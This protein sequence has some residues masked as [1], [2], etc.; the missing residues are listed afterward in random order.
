MCLFIFNFKFNSFC[1]TTTTKTTK[2][3]NIETRLINEKIQ[4]DFQFL[5]K[6]IFLPALYIREKN[7]IHRIETCPR[8]FR[9]K[10]ISLMR[11]KASNQF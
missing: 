9:R 11:L 1:Y 5:L 4:F 3:R 7:L 10:N 8:S 6:N 2:I